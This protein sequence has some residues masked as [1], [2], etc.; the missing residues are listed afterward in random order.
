MEAPRNIIPGHAPPNRRDVSLGWPQ[1]PRMGPDCHYPEN[2]ITGQPKSP[3]SWLSLAPTLPIQTDFLLIAMLEVPADL[4]NF[5]DLLWTAYIP[6]QWTSFSSYWVWIPVWKWK[7][8][9]HS[10]FLT[11]L[12]LP[13]HLHSKRKDEHKLD[14]T[15]LHSNRE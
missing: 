3:F 6:F 13:W 7:H 2:Q 11:F 9:W 14:Q 5:W 4:F 8:K 1:Q 12:P 15:I 10:S